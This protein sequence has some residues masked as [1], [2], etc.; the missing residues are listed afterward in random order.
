MNRSLSVVVPTF[1]ERD[2]IPVLTQGIQAVFLKHAIEGEILIIDDNSQDGSRE[3][4]EELAVDNSAFRFIIRQPPPSLSRAWYEGFD[5]ARYPVVVCM[6]ADLCHDPNDL[7]R[8]LERIPEFD[9]VVGSRYLDNGTAMMRDKS[10]LAAGLSVFSQLVSRKVTGCSGTDISHSFRMFKKTVF[11]SVK[12][13]LCH[14]GNTFMVEFYYL[15]ASRGF[16]IGE[17]SI[18][19]GKRQYGETKLKVGKEGLRYARLLLSILV[20]RI[21]GNR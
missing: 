10:R 18:V 1:N 4:L 19:Y 2:N 5:L 15:V 8:M 7:P 17:I 6:D 13:E 9:M 11:D 16:R 12:S 20:R 21:R 3:V 14:E